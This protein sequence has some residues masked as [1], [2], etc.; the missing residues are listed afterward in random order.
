MLYARF[1]AI[2]WASCSPSDGG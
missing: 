2:P 1:P